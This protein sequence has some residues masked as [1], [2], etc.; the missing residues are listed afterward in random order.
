MKSRGIQNAINRLAGARKLGSPSLLAQA[1]QEAQHILVQARAW[2]ARTPAPAP[3]EVD[4][5]YT[6]IALAVDKLAQALASQA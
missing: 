5:R 3:G 6:P 2:L 4:E 1:E